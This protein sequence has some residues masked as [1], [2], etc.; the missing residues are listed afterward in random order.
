MRTQGDRRVLII[1]ENLPVPFD[2][3]VWQEAMTLRDAGYLVT[4]ICPTGRGHDERHERID[5]IEI[6][7]HP[8]PKE[9]KGALSYL[10][11][12]S[13]A[14]FWEFFLAW[15]VYFGRGFDVIQ[16]CNPP[17]LIFLVAGVFR[18]F[19]VRYVFDH[20]DINPELY[21]LKFGRRDLFYRLLVECEK[22][23]FRLATVS[24]ATNE[25]Y[26]EIAL[27]RG[28]MPGDRVFVVRSSP[29]LSKLGSAGS[30]VSLRLGRR[31][32]VGYVGIMAEQDGVDTLLRIVREIVIGRQREDVQFLLVGDGSELESLKQYAIDLGI[33][34]HVTFTGYLSGENLLAAMNSIDVGVCPDNSNPYNDKCTMNKILEYMSLGKPVVQFGLTEGR[35]SAGNASLYAEHNDEQE[36][37]DLLLSLIDDDAMRAELGARG[38][39]RI[40][41]ELDWRFQAPRLLE[42]YEAAFSG[43]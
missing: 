18:L 37:A 41:E 42:A 5:G 4:V 8:L 17:D 35:R 31:H 23:T 38:R 9:G 10:K 13:A 36:F 14:L 39:H 34:Q 32:L 40:Q 3:R 11:E 16:G 24:I 33:A 26:R 29:D 19:G 12:Y 7:R 27:E 2:R 25:S 21:E 22:A 43:A 6:F 15:R 1:V 20:H 30:D 28:G